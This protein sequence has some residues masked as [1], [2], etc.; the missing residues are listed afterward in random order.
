MNDDVSQIEN[1]ET[2]PME[3]GEFALLE[4]VA[5]EE[6][7]AFLDWGQ[8]KDL[9]LPYAE[10]DGRIDVGEEIIVYTY[11][12]KADRV[13]AS[14]RLNRNKAKFEM[15][16]QAGDTVDLL[17]AARTDM[18]YKAIIDNK[19]MGLLFKNEVFQEIHYGQ[20]VKGY[21]KALIPAG[22]VDLSL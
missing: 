18:G 4:V 12:D 6:V 9:F 7:G 5:I 10:Q 1:V 21:I 16:Y 14:M 17:I 19:H 11:L 2:P 22:K 13:T 3:L 20:Q 8:P 15:K